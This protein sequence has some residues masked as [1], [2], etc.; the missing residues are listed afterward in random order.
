MCSKQF[1]GSCINIANWLA[2]G[3]IL[4]TGRITSALQKD[5]SATATP[6]TVTQFSFVSFS[7][8]LHHAFPCCFPLPTLRLAGCIVGKFSR[9]AELQIEKRNDEGRFLCPSLLSPIT[10]LAHSFRPDCDQRSRVSSKHVL[11]RYWFGLC[12]NCGSRIWFTTEQRRQ[13]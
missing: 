10:L 11:G 5:S 9:Q 3:F 13:L 8:F 1:I 12:R 4:D 7:S 6:V 2:D